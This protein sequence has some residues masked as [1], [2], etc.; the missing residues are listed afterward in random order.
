[1]ASGDVHMTFTLPESLFDS[2][3]VLLPDLCGTVAA[4]TL[5]GTLAALPGLTGRFSSGVINAGWNEGNYNA[6]AY[7]GGTNSSVITGTLGADSLTGTLTD[8]TLDG[9][10]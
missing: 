8:D 3:T 7:N 6:G 1:M 2:V 9:E 4:S 10:V 5:D